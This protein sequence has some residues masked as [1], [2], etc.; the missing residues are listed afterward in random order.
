[1]TFLPQNRQGMVHVLLLL[2][3]ISGHL[4]Y[5]C[6]Y[7]SRHHYL[8]EY[9]LVNPMVSCDLVFVGST[10][11][12]KISFKNHKSLKNI[13]YRDVFLFKNIKEGQLHDC[14]N[15][16]FSFSS[17]LWF[18]HWNLLVVVLP[19]LSLRNLNFMFFLNLQLLA[20][21]MQ[22]YLNM[23]VWKNFFF[24]VCLNHYPIDPSQRWTLV[25]ILHG[26]K[27]RFLPSLQPVSVSVLPISCFKGLGSSRVQSKFSSDSKIKEK[28]LIIKEC[29]VAQKVWEWR[30]EGKKRCSL[31]RISVFM[32]QLFLWSFFFFFKFHLLLHLRQRL[33][34]TEYS[35]N[36]S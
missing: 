15:T 14:K 20:L 13:P 34:L 30:Q 4:W 26:K 1:M 28:F 10:F 11:Q 29:A 2:L 12:K 21:Y 32:G 7:L 17:F 9:T 22:I 36:I 35:V 8:S 31:S 33:K 5:A 6:M 18:F 27:M 24:F 16:L 19:K 23:L 3:I 25:L